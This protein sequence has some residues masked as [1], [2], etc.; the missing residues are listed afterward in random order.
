MQ[1]AR[2]AA[3]RQLP[4]ADEIFLDHVGHFVRAPEAASKALIRRQ[5]NAAIDSG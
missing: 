4:V 5:L 1:D 3:D 2:S